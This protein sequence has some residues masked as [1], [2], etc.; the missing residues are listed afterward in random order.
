MQIHNPGIIYDKMS[1][2]YRY[3]EVFIPYFACQNTLFRPL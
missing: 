1:T 2:R 3:L